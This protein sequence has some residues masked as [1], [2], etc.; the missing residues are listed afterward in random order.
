MENGKLLS[1]AWFTG[2][3]S[4]RPLAGSEVCRPSAVLNCPRSGHT[5]VLLLIILI[6]LC[7]NLACYE[8]LSK[9]R[10]CVNFPCEKIIRTL[11]FSHQLSILWCVLALKEHLGHYLGNPLKGYCGIALK[12]DFFLS[13]SPVGVFMG[14]T[15]QLIS[16]W[17][18]WIWP[19]CLIFD[20]VQCLK[21]IV[22]PKFL[23]Y[24]HQNSKH[25]AWSCR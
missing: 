19:C 22:R 20:V 13:L 16:F 23:F 14:T 21:K 12:Y 2:C 11:G 17:N 4:D 9:L 15:R 7:W 24:T 8:Y 18:L 3:L 10:V 25:V 6:V 1:L 5:R